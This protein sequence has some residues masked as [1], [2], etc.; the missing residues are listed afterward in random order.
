MKFLNSLKIVQDIQS[1]FE[2][3]NQNKFFRYAAPFVLLVVGSSFALKNFTS[4]RF[5]CFV[6]SYLL[7]FEF[8]VDVEI[9]KRPKLLSAMQLRSS[10]RTVSVLGFY[11]VVKQ[12]NFILYDLDLILYRMRN[13]FQ[14]NINSQQCAIATISI[15]LVPTPNNCKCKLSVWLKRFIPLLNFLI[16]C[17]NKDGRCM[18]A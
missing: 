12:I 11:N 13:T 6:S 2:R 14:S 18:V 4:L 3:W 9:M 1:T 17:Q 16:Q 15:F 5:V 7:W 8:C 10:T